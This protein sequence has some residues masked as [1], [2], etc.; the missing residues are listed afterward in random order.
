MKILKC[1]TFYYEL[2]EGL[3]GTLSGE[4][5]LAFSLLPPFSGEVNSYKKEFASPE[6]NS[7]F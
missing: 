4:A 1:G 6:A 3:L 5:T 2:G 7:F